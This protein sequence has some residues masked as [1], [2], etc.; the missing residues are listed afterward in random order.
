[1]DYALRIISKKRYTVNEMRKKLGGFLEREAKIGQGVGNAEEE[2]REMMNS[3]VS[4]VDGVGIAVGNNIGAGKMDSEELAIGESIGMGEAKP[5]LALVEQAIERLI[6]LNYLNDLEYAKHYISDRARFRP[7]GKMMIQRELMARGIAKEELQIAF[8][9]GE[10][11]YD[12]SG[13]AEEL[14]RRKERAWGGLDVK[15]KREKAYRFLQSK[16]FGRDT[17]YKVLRSCYN[18]ITE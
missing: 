3:N 1:M 7:R 15:K 10:E 17:I 11:A 8:V 5:R 4:G 18:Q 6:E 14:I 2:K 13:S 12:E 16:G 9:D